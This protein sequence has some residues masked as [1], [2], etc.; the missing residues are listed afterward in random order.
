ML[1]IRQDD[2]DIEPQR[3]SCTRDVTNVFAKSRSLNYWFVIEIIYNYKFYKASNT[4]LSYVH[5]I[6]LRFKSRL[7]FD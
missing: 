6:Q 4:K 2:S 3:E 7:N 1:Q 5:Y